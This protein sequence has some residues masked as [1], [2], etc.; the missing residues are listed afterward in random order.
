M[1]RLALG[2]DVGGTN[3]KGAIVDVD[4]GI[5]ISD[6][7]KIQTPHGA[8]KEGINEVVKSISE[9]LDWNSGPIGIGFPSIIRDNM[10]CSAT[11]ISDEW[12]DTDLAEHFGTLL[13]NPVK[14]LND[15]D[16]AGIAE[17][18][19]GAN[20]AKDG[21]VILLT[22]GTGIGSALFLDGKLIPNTEF[23][24]LK[25]NGNILE[26]YA[27]NKVRKDLSLEL[28]VW[29]KRLNEVLEHIHRIISPKLIIVGGGISKELENYQHNFTVQTKVIPARQRNNSG[30]IGAALYSSQ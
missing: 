23:G 13:G 4:A 25:L 26:K 29:A 19:F 17:V 12:L 27:S 30:I 3:T 22:I 8:R 15:A 28:N 11:N 20:G 18:N 14:C 6:K 2:I 7:V 16:A 10:C 21:T 9:S 24:L 5:L 1:Q